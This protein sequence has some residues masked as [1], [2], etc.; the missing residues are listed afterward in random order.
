M[1]HERHE[2]D[3]SDT[4]LQEWHEYDTILL[5]EWH[6]SATRVKNFDFDNDM[7]E[8]IFSHPML[9][10]YQMKGYKEKEQF[11]SKNYVL[12]MLARISKCVSKVHHKNWTL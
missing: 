4:M 8:N 6:E 2:W 1:R 9:A 11:H 7:S 5:N 10:T 3:Q 12:E